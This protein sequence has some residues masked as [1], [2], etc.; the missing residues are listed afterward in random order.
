MKKILPIIVT[1][2]AIA[3]NT[4]AQTTVFDS[5]YSM[6][7]F[8][9]TKEYYRIPAI[10]NQNGKLW[11]FTDD[12]T[13]ATGD[14]GSGKIK[15]IAKTSTG[16]STWSS[17]STIANYS[18]SA[19]SGFDYAHGDAAVVCDRANSNNMLMMCASGSVAYGNSTAS[20]PIRVGRYVT[21]DG[22]S[23]WT[24]KEV[25]DDIYNIW[26][27]STKNSISKL[28]FSSG[29]ICQSAIIKTGSYYRLYAA[30]C[31]NVGSLVVY[32]DD[33][34]NTWNALGGVDA[35]PV[36]NGDE[37]KIEELPNGN[38]LISS[39]TGGRYFN[40]YTYTNQSTAAGSW[41]TYSTASIGSSN[42]TN[43]EIL[44]VPAMASGSNKPIYIA[45]QSIPAGPDRSNVSIYWK[46]LNSVSDLDEPSDF[47]SDWKQYQVSTTTS[48]YSTMTLDN[49]GN[50]AFLY[51]ETYL[52]NGACYDIKFRS[53][54][55]QT[56]TSNAYTYTT[57]LDEDS[58]RTAFLS[59][60]TIQDPWEGKVVTLKAKLQVSGQDPKYFYLHNEGLN[61]KVEETEPK[62]TD[63]SYYWVISKDP[64]TSTYYLSSLKGDG[65]LG[66]GYGRDYS[67]EDENADGAYKENIPVCTDDYT[68]TFA[69]TGFVKQE[70]V[71]EDDAVLMDGYAIKFVSGIDSNG[72]NTYRYVAVSEKGAINWFDHTAKG[73]YSNSGV[74]PYWTTDFE[75][76]EV[77][78]VYTPETYG[79]W[80][81]PTH[82]GFPVRMTRSDDG[83][84]NQEF[85]GYYYYATLK[86]P[87]AIDLTKENVK[88]KDNNKDNVSGYDLTVLTCKEP[89]QNVG[90]KVILDDGITTT[91]KADGSYT[92]PR[93]TPVML[94]MG[95][96]VT[97]KYTE[98]E[99]TLYLQPTFAKPIIKDTGFRGTLG[100]K[101]FQN[102]DVSKDDYYNPADKNFFILG[103][104]ISDGR[105][106]FYY[107]SNLTLAAN[108]AYY[109]FDT[110]TTGAKPTSLVFCFTDDS[111]T[112]GITQPEAIEP[113]TDGII[114]DLSGR[115]ITSAVKKGIYIR[116]G[117]KYIV[118]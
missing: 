106:K 82:F 73:E 48:A 79:T 105:M 118:K 115:R 38:V 26:S 102:T 83:K 54:S 65:Y 112:T 62:L 64:G 100:K 27:S 15:I 76:T 3:V 25:T 47:V 39:R 110:T 90:E 11:A 28:F 33:F 114:Y 111:F 23:N 2:L 13:A 9:E 21:T 116:D 92:L 107:L 43:G 63:Y 70:T 98:S 20:N 81:K 49:S 10:L 93:E 77:E 36:P 31:T 22:G 88:D 101:T 84:G 1:M 18:S 86:L 96:H 117:K 57:A 99:I 19:T 61:L 8:W 24:G 29:R 7:L 74:A 75:I 16:G 67:I 91:L 37:A 59:G 58:H 42:A 87:F 95:E 52:S 97:A 14:I 32:S 80:E 89:K 109:V 30:L 55:L 53:L 40:I 71:S 12:R 108:K 51:E 68:N 85:E 35:V 50:I 69:I 17:S 66:K 46:A 104:K 34:G 78:R 94:R 56:I 6:V 5:Q 4:V 113:D 60:S 103:K 41:G 44:L 45:L 72:N